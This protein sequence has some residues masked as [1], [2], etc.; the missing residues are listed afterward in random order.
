VPVAQL[1]TEQKDILL[2]KIYEKDKKLWLW[3]K[4]KLDKLISW[5]MGFRVPGDGVG[6]FQH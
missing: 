1:H 4:G 6:I 5:R 3:K 2:I